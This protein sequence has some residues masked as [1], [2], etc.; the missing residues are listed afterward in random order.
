MRNI[1]KVAKDSLNNSKVALEKTVEGIIRNVVVRNDSV[2]GSNVTVINVK[3]HA[4]AT[5]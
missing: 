5:M 4:N 1:A 2:T 3:L